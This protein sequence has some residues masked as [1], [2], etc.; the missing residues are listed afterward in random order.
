MKA[1]SG[2]MDELNELVMLVQNT[3][4]RQQKT[5]Q[6]CFLESF[7]LTYGSVFVWLVVCE[8]MNE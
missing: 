3:S 7:C 8:E 4:Q 6:K 5:F 2:L 1:G